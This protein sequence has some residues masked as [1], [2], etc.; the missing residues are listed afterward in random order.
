M[1]ECFGLSLCFLSFGPSSILVYT[2]VGTGGSSVLWLWC[3]GSWACFKGGVGIFWGCWGGDWGGGGPAQNAHSGIEREWFLN[4]AL[5]HNM[6]QNLYT[7]WSS[8]DIQACFTSSSQVMMIS[9]LNKSNKDVYCIEILYKYD[10][11]RFYM[12]ELAVMCG[13]AAPCERLLPPVVQF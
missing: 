1:L 10:H 3:W 13:A 7:W 12:H 9:H 11:G 8:R 2:C 5:R 4:A 6:V